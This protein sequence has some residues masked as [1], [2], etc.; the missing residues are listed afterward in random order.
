MWNKYSNCQR[1]FENPKRFLTQVYIFF[2]IWQYFFMYTFAKSFCQQKKR[3]KV[4]QKINK[5]KIKIFSQKSFY[6][7]N[8][9]Q[10]ITTLKILK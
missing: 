2:H 4:C 8:L 9:S 10:K 5:K 3:I 7:Q 6:Q 1:Q